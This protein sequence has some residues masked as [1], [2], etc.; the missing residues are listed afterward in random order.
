[1]KTLC[2]SDVKE[3]FIERFKELNS[4]V[5]ST[6][7]KDH[8]TSRTVYC[9]VDGLDIYFITS[10][11]YTK[12]KQI[13]KNPKVALCHEKIQIEG[14][15]EIIGHPREC[16]LPT[17]NEDATNYIEQFSKYKNTVLI[18]VKPTLVTL[19]KGRGYYQYLYILE[20]KALSKGLER[21][22]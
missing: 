11:A 15:A 19:Y 1:M 12:Y 18:R 8:V 20:E 13:L 10:K 5:L 16:P 7:Y 14:I 9:F 6:S 2:F 21:L 4:V 17:H 22:E 3:D